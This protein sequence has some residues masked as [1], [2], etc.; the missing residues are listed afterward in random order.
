[1]KRHDQES[2]PGRSRSVKRRTNLLVTLSVLA[3]MLLVGGHGDTFAA[4]ARVDINKAG[5]EEL[6]ALPGIGQ[7]KAEAIVHE[8]KNGRFRS[9]DDLAR[10][11]GIGDKTLAQLRD[12]VMVGKEP[13]P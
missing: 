3:L 13:A 7:S 1:M 12:H 4:G 8:R 5:V 6:T 2:S 9:V 10:V 11:S